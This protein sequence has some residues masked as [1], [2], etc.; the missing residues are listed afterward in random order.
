MC[1]DVRLHLTLT[2][3]NDSLELEE[4]LRKELENS[5]SSMIT[6]KEDYAKI[7]DQ[8]VKIVKYVQFL[9]TA[10]FNEIFYNGSVNISSMQRQSGTLAAEG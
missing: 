10:I 5:K 3:Q 2:F 4:R 8:L 9:N 1:H 7:K 6:L